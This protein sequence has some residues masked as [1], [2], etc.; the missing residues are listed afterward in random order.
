MI[1]EEQLKA[2]MSAHLEHR[3]S[4]IREEL[5]RRVKLAKAG[6]M[7]PALAREVSRRDPVTFINDWVWTFDPR[8]PADGIPAR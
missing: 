4:R 2:W 7:N 5:I 6:R 8:N 3:R 1:T